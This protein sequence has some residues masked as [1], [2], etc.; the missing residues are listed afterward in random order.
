MWGLRER[1]AIHLPS[2][3][4]AVAEAMC[5]N[6]FPVALFDT[7]D[8]VLGGS[9]GDSTFILHELLH[10]KA[11]GWVVTISDPE[12]VHEAIRLGLDGHFDLQVGGKRDRL[13]GDPVRIRGTVR[14]LHAGRYMEPEVRHGGGR[15]HYLGH[16]A[17]IEVEGSRPDLQNLLLLTTLRSH[18]NSIH[19]IVSCGIYPERQKILVAKGTVAPRAAYAP[20]A[21][22]IVLVDSPGA[23]AVNPTRFQYKRARPGLFGM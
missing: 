1:T 23:T 17:V 4:K 9:A 20:I 11:E 22:S 18:P 2:P 19:Q 8:N 15:F 6:A 10:Q 7:G 5:A 13:H 21:K 3:S 12:A 14:S 16:S